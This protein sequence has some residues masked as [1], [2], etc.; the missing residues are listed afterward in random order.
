MR[1]YFK[2][3]YLITL[4]LFTACSGHHV[5]LNFPDYTDNVPEIETGYYSVHKIID[6]VAS[7]DMGTEFLGELIYLYKDDFFIDGKYYSGIKGSFLPN[8]YIKT[9]LVKNKNVYYWVQADDEDIKGNIEFS[10]ITEEKLVA[11]ITTDKNQTE[12]VE[13]RYY[14][15]QIRNDELITMP[16][17]H[18]GICYQPPNN[19]DG[20]FPA[21]TFPGFENALA[22]GY[23]G[24]EF[25]VRVTKDKRFIVSHD[26][27]L[28][29]ATTM[30]GFVKDKNLSEFKNALVIK[31]AYIPESKATAYE[32]FIATPMNSLEDVLK[33]FIDDPRLDK[34][35]VDIKPDT[36]ENIYLAAKHDFEGLN[37]EQQQKILFLTREES[38]AELLREI[39]PF[40]DIIFRKLLA[41]QEERIIL[42]HLE[43]I[44]YWHLSPLKLVRK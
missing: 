31:S 19:Y 25:D 32:A 10:L 17:A 16:L 3:F 26:E 29:A 21:N 6:G 40:S 8:Y 4:F 5:L 7:T 14:G 13:M 9:N 1:L 27:D 22:S 28:S 34:M 12:Q 42:F 37:T 35:V 30:R 2:Y 44:L 23:K 36:D 20:I 24:F 11:N 15:K 43:P 33:H 41:Y 18:R 38:T 39:C